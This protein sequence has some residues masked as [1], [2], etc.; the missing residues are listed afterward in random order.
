MEEYLHALE[1]G[2]RPSRDQ[3]LARYEDIAESLVEALDGLDFLDQVAPQL[4]AP[5][6]SSA[7][8]DESHSPSQLAR[9]ALG[10][11]RLIRE[12]GRGGMGIVYEAE[13]LSLGR[14]VA[15]KVLPFTA[16]H[17]TD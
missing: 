13:Q 11:F 2:E 10:D 9:V 5:A 14:R 7:T 8:S 17:G 1:N 16:R 3:F 15:V 4:A 6:R 12:V